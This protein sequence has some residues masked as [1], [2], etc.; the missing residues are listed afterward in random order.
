[1]IGLTCS[2]APFRLW[3][4]VDHFDEALRRLPL[5]QSGGRLQRRDHPDRAQE[6]MSA[7]LAA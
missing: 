6:P 5:T 7:A 2:P 4:L 1:M 3:H